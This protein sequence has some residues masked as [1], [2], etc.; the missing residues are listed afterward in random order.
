MGEEKSALSIMIAKACNRRI[1]R[2]PPLPPT[3]SRTCLQ[4]LHRSF[5]TPRRSR[6]T[7]RGRHCDRACARG[8]RPDHYEVVALDLIVLNRNPGSEH[9][10]QLIFAFK[11]LH[12]VTVSETDVIVVKASEDRLI[13]SFSPSQNSPIGGLMDHFEGV[14]RD[15]C[16]SIA[17]ELENNWV[18]GGGLCI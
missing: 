9:Y 4:L 2:F 6:N 16:L 1:H 7:A 5:Q 15:I 13:S 12:G 8:N 3:G 11:K 10:K 17:P 14:T 18:S